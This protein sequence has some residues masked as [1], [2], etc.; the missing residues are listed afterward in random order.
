VAGRPVAPNL[1]ALAAGGSHAAHAYSHVGFTTFSLQS[2]FTG[3]LAPVAGGPS[4]VRDFLA[5]GYEVGIFSG[6]AEDFGGTAEIVGMRE[7]AVFVDGEHMA[8][9]GDEALVLDTTHRL[10]DAELEMG[11]HGVVVVRH[12]QPSPAW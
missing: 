11:Q 2:L 4:L 5:N 8:E 6:Q 12:K 3:R 7:G 9:A 1:E 10:A